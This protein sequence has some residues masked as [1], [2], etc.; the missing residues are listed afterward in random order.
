VGQGAAGVL[1]VRA[2][3]PLELLEL[4]GLS[5]EEVL[6][7]GVDLAGLLDRLPEVGEDAGVD[8]VESG[9][10]RRDRVASQAVVVPGAVLDD[11]RRGPLGRPAQGRDPLG[12]LVGVATDQLDLRVDHLV[13]AAEVRTHH[14]PV[15]ML[16]RQVQIVVG[17]ESPL[18]Q[19]RELRR[20]LLGQSRDGVGRHGVIVR[21]DEGRQT[22]LTAVSN[23]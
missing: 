15:H 6:G 17:A 5:D 19:L 8:E 16:E 9:E 22:S 10:V 1:E 13:D 4:T 14:V 23:A 21:E 18:Q 7:H 20:A 2:D 3:E 11:R 12:D